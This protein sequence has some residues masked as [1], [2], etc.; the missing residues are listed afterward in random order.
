V[1]ERGETLS[2]HASVPTDAKPVA[3][4]PKATPVR[5]AARAT[6]EVGFETNSIVVSAS[7]SAAV[8]PIVIDREQGSAVKVKWR[9]RADSAQ[10]GIDYTPVDAGVARLNER[11]TRQMLYVPLRHNSSGLAERSFIVELQT[12]TGDAQL[13]QRTTTRV[14]IRNR[15]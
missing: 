11:Q 2:E 4:A 15:V 10:P 14:I 1:R 12:V 9:T 13:G 8:I 5:S 3:A 6:A 7:A